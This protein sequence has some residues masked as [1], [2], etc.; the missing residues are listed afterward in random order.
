MGRGLLLV[1]T[2][3]ASSSAAFAQDARGPDIGISSG[4]SKALHGDLDYVA[5]MV[6]V[7]ARFPVAAHLAIEPEL[8]FWPHTDT[9][10]FDPAIF[11]PPA[12][13]SV[14]VTDGRD[15]WNAS[16]NL[17]ARGRIDRVELFAGG[18]AGFYWQLES[19]ETVRL[20]TGQRIV[21]RSGI[22]GPE[23]GVQG[24]AGAA[25]HVTDRVSLTGTFRVESRDVFRDPGGGAAYQVLAGV[26][27]R[28]K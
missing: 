26:R 4:M 13:P 28:L 1:I 5:P 6:H 22:R 17:L 20:D 23:A 19:F 25:V 7:S 14:E 2:W 3:L 15:A 12:T 21:S 24:V 18:G 11:A 10:R 16:L 9:R 8:G 27:F